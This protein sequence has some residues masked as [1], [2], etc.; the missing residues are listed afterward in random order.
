MK[1]FS[2]KT[3]NM[4]HFGENISCIGAR[5]QFC[6]P[7]TMTSDG[8]ISDVLI[9]RMGKVLHN[10][11]STTPHYSKLPSNSVPFKEQDH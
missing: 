6:L 4:Y 1:M 2:T 3:G 11:N 9:H 10:S 8:F 7:I 5:E